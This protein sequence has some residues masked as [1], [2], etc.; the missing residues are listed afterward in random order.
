M[1][2]QPGGKQVNLLM[3]DLTFGPSFKA[4]QGSPIVKGPK[5]Q[6][7]LLLVVWHVK[8]TSRKSCPAA[9]L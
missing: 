9:F 1:S 5:T 8:P 6:L 2:N 7:L 3:S 4:K